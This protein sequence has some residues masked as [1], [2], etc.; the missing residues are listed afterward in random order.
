MYFN[1]CSQKK[2]RIKKLKAEIEELQAMRCHVSDQVNSL[3]EEHTVFSQ[4]HASLG[5]R[6]AEATVLENAAL[7]KRLAVEMSI[8]EGEMGHR[9]SEVKNHQRQSYFLQQEVAR[10]RGL[11]RVLVA[12]LADMDKKKGM[13][14]KLMQIQKKD[15]IYAAL[16][17]VNSVVDEH[18]ASQEGGDDDADENQSDE[19]KEEEEE[20][21]ELLQQP[22]DCEMTEEH[23]EGDPPLDAC[24]SVFSNMELEASSYTFEHS[25]E[26]SK[27]EQDQ[28]SQGHSAPPEERLPALPVVNADRIVDDL[29]AMAS[30]ISSFAVSS[31]LEMIWYV[32]GAAEEVR[33]AKIATREYVSDCLEDAVVNVAT[34]RVLSQETVLSGLLAGF[35]LATERKVKQDCHDARQQLITGFVDSSLTTALN[36]ARNIITHEAVAKK[37][38]AAQRLFVLSNEL[39]SRCVSS[40]FNSVMTAVVVKHK[41]EQLEAQRLHE[42]KQQRVVEQVASVCDEFAYGAIGAALYT[43][44]NKVLRYRQAMDAARAL[45]QDPNSVG[46]L[47]HPAGAGFALAKMIKQQNRPVQL[48]MYDIDAKTGVQHT[49]PSVTRSRGDPTVQ[50][51]IDEAL[52]NTGDDYG[53]V[54]FGKALGVIHQTV[55]E[56]EEWVFDAQLVQEIDLVKLVAASSVPGLERTVT[57]VL[58]REQETDLENTRNPANFIRFILTSALK[59]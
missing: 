26:D 44:E 9:A 1:C 23:E 16:I 46:V 40:V 36:V 33:P 25:L 59:G 15:G 3:A 31:A 32:M 52:A 20:R 10:R 30:N 55:V 42:E 37:D 34:S 50:D 2:A 29:N 35:Q 53:K 14:K 41:L 11:V 27:V 48:E 24:L 49:F 18:T 6:R 45:S 39:A 28:G 12:E 13:K 57:F 17:K 7:V 38:R 4:Q 51:L 54:M 22:H 43:V 21:G 58:S 19:E 5:R 56:F 8:L 47:V